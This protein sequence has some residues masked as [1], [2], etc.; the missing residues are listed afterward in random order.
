MG[1]TP[2][3]DD[4]VAIDFEAAYGLASY[5]RGRHQ[6]SV[7]YDTFDIRD[8][9][10]AFGALDDNNERGDAWTVSYWLRTGER[11]RLAVEWMRVDSERAGR[12][13][14]GLSPQ[15]VEDL[16]QVSFRLSLGSIL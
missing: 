2:G 8:R 12:A 5:L 16:L 6:L 10:V 11:H 4:A 14:L 3:G 15:A 7:R 1:R 9:D 13:T